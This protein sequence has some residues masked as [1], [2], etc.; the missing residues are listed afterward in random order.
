VTIPNAMPTRRVTLSIILFLAPVLVILAAVALSARPSAPE[1]SISVLL[2]PDW[3]GKWETGVP[4]V[5]FIPLYVTPPHR[6]VVSFAR[7][8]ESPAIAEE[9]IRRLGLDKMTPDEL[10]GN[11]TVE[12]DPESAEYIRLTYRDPAR[13][14]PRRARRIVRTV[15]VV[16]ASSIR[17]E[18]PCR[19]AYDY[20]WGLPSVTTLGD[21]GDVKHPPLFSPGGFFFLT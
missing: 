19:C 16:A 2:R 1:A 12:P 5:K 18:I 7:D 13:E 4:G 15:A 14:D 8:I 21:V 20:T 10:L 3:G 17:K 11:L 9:V 6:V